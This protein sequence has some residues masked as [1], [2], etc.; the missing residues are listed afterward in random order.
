VEPATTALDL[1]RTLAELIGLDGAQLGGRSMLA[2]WVG[3]EARG[4]PA[5]LAE[6]RAWRESDLESRSDLA[7]LLRQRAGEPGGH[8]GEQ[9]VLLRSPWKFIWN[10]EGGPE[11]YDLERDPA[12][13]AN[14]AEDEPGLVERFTA[15][16]EAWRASQAAGASVEELDEDTRRMLQALG[17]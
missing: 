9:V 13:S 3:D 17:Y 7:D 4:R 6:R 11:L 15:E 10:A 16:V 2:L 1:P 8:I 5:L 14:R 12:E